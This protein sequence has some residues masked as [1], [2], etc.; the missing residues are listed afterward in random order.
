[1]PVVLKSGSF[2]LLEPSGAVKACNGIALL[3]PLLHFMMEHGDFFTALYRKKM[4]G[5][6]KTGFMSRTGIN[7]KRNHSEKKMSACPYKISSKSINA[8]RAVT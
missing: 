5:S 4:L 2:N 6:R 1:V 8:M 7:N 3:L